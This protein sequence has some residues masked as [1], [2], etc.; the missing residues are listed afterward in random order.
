M[1]RLEGRQSGR[2]PPEYMFTLAEART[3][4]SALDSAIALVAS[5]LVAPCP[6]CRPN[7][8]CD[9]HAADLDMTREYR[10]LRAQLGAI[11]PQ[12]GE[13]WHPDTSPEEPGAPRHAR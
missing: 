6:H 12:P 5:H 11:L 3:V 10:E 2:R 8:P 13:R 9:R 1:P 7:V 4:A